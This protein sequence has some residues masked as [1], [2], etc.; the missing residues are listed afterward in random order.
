MPFGC[1]QH[2][3][4]AGVTQHCRHVQGIAVYRVELGPATQLMPRLDPQ[5][6]VVA[7]IAGDHH[8]RA[9]GQ[10]LGR[11]GQKVLD[12]GDRVQLAPT[13]RMSGRRAVT[14]T[15]AWRLICRPK[16]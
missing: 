13:L 3:A 16:L 14:I 1:R 5:G 12:P 8:L 7:P 11:V 9:A 4:H 10:D 2:P 15:R 6:Q